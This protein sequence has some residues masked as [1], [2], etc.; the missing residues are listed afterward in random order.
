MVVKFML[1]GLLGGGGGVPTHGD[2]ICTILHCIVVPLLLYI[3]ESL[4]FC[5]KDGLCPCQLSFAK[6]LNGNNR[7]K[8]AKLKHKN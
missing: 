5:S 4:L 1:A 3:Y 2:H 8:A 6:A 7:K